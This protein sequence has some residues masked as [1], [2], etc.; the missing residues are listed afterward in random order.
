MACSLQAYTPGATYKH[1]STVL[2]PP[3]HTQATVE[4]KADGAQTVSLTTTLQAGRLLLHWGLEGGKDYQ[5]GWRLPSTCRPPG[6]KQYKDRA[7][8]SPFK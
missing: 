6:T 1:L 2:S 4:Q 3:P 8:Q 5:G 7:L